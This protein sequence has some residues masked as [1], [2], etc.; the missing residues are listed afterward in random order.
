MA[1]TRRP[2]DSTQ[3]PVSADGEQ[4]E[5]KTGSRGETILTVLVC[6]I[7]LAGL[8]LFLLRAGLS[9]EH[10]DVSPLCTAFVT[11]SSFA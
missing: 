10:I 9:P 5:N 11:A 3:A 7:L 1:E 2:D 4:A 6:C 8:G